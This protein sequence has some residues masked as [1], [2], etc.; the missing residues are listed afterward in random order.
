[1]MIKMILADKIINLRKKSGWSQ[2]ELAEKLN[3]SR[4]SISKWEGATSIPDLNKIIQLSQIFG[5]T[6]DYLLKDE[7]EQ[8]VFSG[9]D[10]EDT[11]PRVGLEKAT[12]FLE[13]KRST[14][15]LVATGVM[16]CI[17]A[18]VPLL[19]LVGLSEMANAIITESI[20]EGLGITVLLLMVA[21]AIPLFIRGASQLSDYKIFEKREFEL[22]YGVESIFKEKSISYKA[23]FYQKLS[24]GIA[25]CIISVIPLVLSGILETSEPIQI[26]MVG[27]LLLIVGAGVY[28][29]ITAGVVKEA[30]SQ[31]LGEGEYSGEYKKGNEKVDRVASV[32]WPLVTAIYLG[33]SF[34]T[35]KWYISWVIWPI[36]GLVFG[37]LAGVLKSNKK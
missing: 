19:I 14:S 13:A 4:Q 23:I 27:I 15:K 17:Y 33:Y 16:L 34:I 31:I 5:V 2:E 11:L 26:L 7:L 28:L 37:A 22:E 24:I 20:A 6:T 25:L 3:V 8:E 30:Y 18:V 32:Y 21:L 12:A 35:M 1:M 10:V 36:A 9:E 29:I